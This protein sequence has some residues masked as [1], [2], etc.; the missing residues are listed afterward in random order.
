M[1]ELSIA[2]SLI[3]LVCSHATREGAPRVLAIRLRLG[4]LSAFRR[5]LFFCFDAVSRGTA[6]EGARLSIED[7]PLTVHCPQCDATKRP[8][9][10]YN[11]RCPTCGMPATKVVTG[12]EMQVISI[13]LAYEDELIPEVAES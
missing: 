1:H 3:E 4:E 8:R 2:Q 10:R 13:E 7:V 5:A 12:R 11:F 9:G 6:C